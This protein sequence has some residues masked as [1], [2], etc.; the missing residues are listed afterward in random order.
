[1]RAHHLEPL[2]FL[3]AFLVVLALMLSSL[4]SPSAS[5]PSQWTQNGVPA[6]VL[7]ECGGRVPLVCEDG[8]GGAL[9]AWQTDRDGNEDIYVRRLLGNGVLA[10]GW[11]AI[12]TPAATTPGDER[13]LELVSDGN[14]GAFVAWYDWPNY[15]SYVQH[16]LG[17]GQ[18]APGW[19]AD[20]L[21]L[22]PGQEVNPRMLPDGTGGVFVVWETG[23]GEGG[24]DIFAQH[25]SLDGAP[26][27]GWHDGGIPVCTATGNQGGADL[28]ADGEGGIII[29]WADGRDYFFGEF[30][31]QRITWSGT[32]A[33]GW[34]VDGKR[35]VAALGV[36]P[37]RGIVPDGAGGAYLAWQ[38]QHDPNMSDWEVFAIRLRGD[39]TVA[40]GWPAS[41]LRLTPG[42]GYQQLSSVV[43]D[44]LG[45]VLLGWFDQVHPPAIGYVM[46][47]R[48]DG[49]PAPGWPA[50]GSRV[51]D[52]EGYVLS[53]RLAPDGFGGSYVA[54]VVTGA[55]YHGYVQRLS[56]T[57]TLAPGWPGPGV[58][59]VVPTEF[60]A[61]QQVDLAV[62]TDRRG[63]AIVTWDDTRNG[64]QYQIYAQRY[65]GDG[66]TPVLVSL[67]SAQA[68]PDRVVLAWHDPSRA[69]GD[70]TVYRRRDGQQWA[71][72]GH[73]SFD[74]AGRLQ[75]EDTG[76]SPGERYA[77]RLGWR[78]VV[79]E[80]FSAETWVDVPVALALALEGA[81]PNPAVG[82]FTVAFTLPRAD[83]ATL[84]LLDV[85]GRRVL[86]REVG[87]LGPGQHQI[88]L[89]ECGCT[90]PGMYWLRLT[91]AGRA[92]LKRV[93][94][95][96]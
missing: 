80:Y 77:Y 51:S 15:D 26:V 87:S 44:S 55:G 12:G 22:A 13:L 89:G 83:A 82:S 5:A 75:F 17:N 28:A 39:G 48:P 9:I 46:R 71:A 84:E 90:P 1:M 20:G 81:R 31:A 88:R 63:G 10:P 8:T 23:T 64:S 14:G 41:G 50:G 66:P 56:S 45:G 32:L 91:N 38:Y 30:Y 95:V 33:T 16:V 60:Y 62:T 40:P 67:V 37:I 94:V 4:A 70:A 57:G 92:L 2:A 52:L 42:L 34:P 49:T 35:V 21:S 72:L 74:G 85:A 3:G 78:E 93:A 86:A 47:L 76:I 54:Y 19:P 53:P 73:A 11:P 27:S 61:F 24:G 69:V 7:P 79:S 25:L 6:C 36:G 58:P 68:L 59:L 29:A 96:K 43:A 18:I 65:I